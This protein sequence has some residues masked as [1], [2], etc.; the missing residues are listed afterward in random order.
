M[1]WVFKGFLCIFT[2]AGQHYLV[3][4]T[5]KRVSQRSA[6]LWSAGSKFIVH[7]ACLA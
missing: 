1:A 7:L 6:P 5:S 4:T 2:A 3:T